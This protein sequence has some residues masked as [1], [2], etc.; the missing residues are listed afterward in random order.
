M[1]DKPKEK[2]F[3]EKRPTISIT[4]A[5]SVIKFLKDLC[6][7]LITEDGKKYRLSWL[8]EDMILYIITDE[9]KLE[10][11]L[12]GLVGEAPEEEET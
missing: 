11:F 5:E 3:K 7:N 8:I 1:F 2:I 6:N 9:K 12:N 4:I 10:D